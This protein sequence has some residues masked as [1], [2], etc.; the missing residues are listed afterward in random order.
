MEKNGEI[1]NQGV[2]KLQ[3]YNKGLEEAT[4]TYSDIVI[5]LF[6]SQILQ[7]IF[8][9]LISRTYPFSI[10]VKDPRTGNQLFSWGSEKTLS[11]TQIRIIE[12]LNNNVFSLGLT[13]AGYLF[14]INF[15]PAYTYEVS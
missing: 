6:I 1:I 5:V 4:S 9:R 12:I 7:V 15:F 10:T 2:Q 13:L 3:G 8:H 14:L 11:K